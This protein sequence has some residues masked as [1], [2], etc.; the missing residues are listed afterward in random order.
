VNAATTIFLSNAMASGVRRT[1]ICSIFIDV[2][3]ALWAALFKHR[4]L[5]EDVALILACTHSATDRIDMGAQI[6][7]LNTS[8]FVLGFLL[9]SVFMDFSLACI[10]ALDGYGN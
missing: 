10:H 6:L 7:I 5:Y 9:H 8:I 4:Y 2:S 3:S 1:H